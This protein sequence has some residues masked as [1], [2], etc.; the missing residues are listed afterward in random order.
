MVALWS[1]FLYN[2]RK[3]MSC[4]I[5]KRTKKSCC[6]NTNKTKLLSDCMF[7]LQQALLLLRWK[8]YRPFVCG[9][10][11]KTK[12][13]MNEWIV[14]R[15]LAFALAFYIFRCMIV[16]L[17][18]ESSFFGNEIL[19]SAVEPSIH[20]T[21]YDTTNPCCF[22]A[23]QV[24]RTRSRISV[25]SHIT[26]PKYEKNILCSIFPHTDTVTGFDQFAIVCMLLIRLRQKFHLILRY[27]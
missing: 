5:D 15:A 1:T 18:F 26:K 8:I 9:N 27:I 6:L 21:P 2:D 19:R 22:G 10:N 11:K 20:H 25:H 17:S 24:I 16:G 12:I 4:A 23:V 13:G 7:I 14:R 3:T